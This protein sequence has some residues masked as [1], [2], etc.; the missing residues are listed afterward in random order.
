MSPKKVV[1]V[2]GTYHQAQRVGHRANAGLRGA[3]ELIVQEYGVQI[4]VEEWW[5]HQEASFAATL[6]TATL[7]YANVGTPDEP[8]FI[9]PLNV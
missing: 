9:S 8:R 1:I 7:K 6:E 3:I 2:L 4:I 5:Y